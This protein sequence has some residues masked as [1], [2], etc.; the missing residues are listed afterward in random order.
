[1][2]I[3]A[4]RLKQIIEEELETLSNQHT[5]QVDEEGGLHREEIPI[6]SAAFMLLT[7]ALDVIHEYRGK[8]E[9][10]REVSEDFENIHEKLADIW[11]EI[12]RHKDLGGGEDPEGM[13]WLREP[14]EEEGSYLKEDKAD[15]ESI[16][17]LV[18][19]KKK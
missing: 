11:T 19:I 3:K 2:K 18:E 17:K 12:D 10:D 15:S 5:E 8:S 6:A 16:I 7:K 13:E 1:M 9:D 14:S 4:D